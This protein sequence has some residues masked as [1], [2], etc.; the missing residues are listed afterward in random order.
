MEP[1]VSEKSSDALESMFAKAKANATRLE[2]FAAQ[3]YGHTC[4]TNVDFTGESSKGMHA[5]I[6]LR[7]YG[8]QDND[9]LLLWA[10]ELFHTLKITGLTATKNARGVLIE[11][12]VESDALAQALDERIVVIKPPKVPNYKERGRSKH[13]AQDCRR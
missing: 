3:Q 8:T 11:G 2:K 6:L 10:K 4:Q 9:K 12:P 1:F 7:H 13:R 5:A